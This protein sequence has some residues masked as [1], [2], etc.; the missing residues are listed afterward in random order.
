[1]HMN[2][3]IGIWVVIALLVGG[4]VGYMVPRPVTPGATN[5]PATN[6]ISQKEVDL[7]QAMRK[8][9]SDHV[10]WTRA[11]AGA[12]IA[13]APDADQAAARLLKNQEEIGA[14]VAQYYGTAAGSQ[15]TQLLK[16]HILIAVDVVKAAKAGDQAKLKE[17]DDRW[18]A[19]AAAIA[20]FLSTANPNW[21]KAELTSMLNSHLALTTE[22]VTARLNKDWA[23]DVATFD[24]IFNQAMDM[25]D[26][27]SGGIVKQFPAKF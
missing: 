20:N 18:K 25:A 6:G 7:R 22:E 9:W 8:L 21:S 4:L 10:W 11:Y 13:G 19:N 3:N 15:L 23:K 24:R 12:A 2:K 27:L 5:A 14:A 17:A 26:V 1:M 16:D